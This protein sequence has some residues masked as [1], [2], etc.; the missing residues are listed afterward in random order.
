M[1][2]GTVSPSLNNTGVCTYA[3]G[4]SLFFFYNSKPLF[5]DWAMRVAGLSWVDSS[6]PLGQL[7]GRPRQDTQLAK[8]GFEHFKIN[9]ILIIP[10]VTKFI[11][12]VC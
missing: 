4:H 1:S 6:Y 2:V 11:T 12:P 9:N 7:P 8:R 10:I 5:G 3:A